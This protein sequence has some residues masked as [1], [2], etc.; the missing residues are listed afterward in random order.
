MMS[1]NYGNQILWPVYIIIGNLD[2]KLWRSLNR[3]EILFLGFILIVYEQSEAAN[4]KDKDLKARIYQMALKTM[5]QYTYPSLF[6]IDIKKNGDT[7]D[8]IALLR[9]K[10]GIQLVFVDGYK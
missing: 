5:L 10:D 3:P 6:S 4:N 1:L 9:Y 7:N 8:V 2:A